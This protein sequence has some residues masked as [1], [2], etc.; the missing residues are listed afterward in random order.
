MNGALQS[1]VS[2]SSTPTP[3]KPTR[4]PRR[5]NKQIFIIFERWSEESKE[6]VFWRNFFKSA[7]EGSLPHKFHI[8]NNQLI[9][10]IR[11]RRAISITENNM[12]EV[13]DFIT[14]MGIVSNRLQSISTQAL[15]KPIVIEWNNLRKNKAISYQY[16]ITWAKWQQKIY[17]L[18]EI[19]YDRLLALLTYAKSVNQLTSSTVTIS[20][21][22]IE[23]ISNIVFNSTYRTFQLVPPPIY[24]FTQ[25]TSKT[26][27]KMSFTTAWQNYLNTVQNYTK[28]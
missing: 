28:S 17:N 3:T 19:E 2:S 8:A 26:G 12:Q 11:K 6:D 14:S 9:C 27:T 4:R 22:R 20:Y 1:I 15:R 18:N 5:K 24:R 25:S 23:S 21:S 10:E 7:S 16:L 13:K